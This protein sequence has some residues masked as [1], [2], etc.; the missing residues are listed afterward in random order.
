MSQSLPTFGAANCWNAITPNGK[1]VYVS[2]A[3]S[4]TIS[5]FAI[6]KGGALTPIAGT[7]VGTNPE[8]SVNLDIAVSGDNKYLFTL[9]SGSGTIGIF[10]IQSNGALTQVD[11]IGG[12]P[13]SAGFNGIAAR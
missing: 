10:A 1:W 12:L 7:V 11:E 8:G 3:G 5:G 13:K 6:G 4:S 2:N 9:N